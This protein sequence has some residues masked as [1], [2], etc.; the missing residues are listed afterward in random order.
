M[1]AADN[2]VDI[3]H[4]RLGHINESYLRIFCPF[5]P[6]YLSLSFC[7]ECAVCKQHKQP[8]TKTKTHIKQIIKQ[9]N[10]RNINK[11][12]II[13]DKYIKLYGRHKPGEYIVVDLKHMPP[14]LDGNLFLCTFTDKSTRLSTPVHLKLKSSFKYHYTT[15]LEYIKNKTGHYPKYIHS[16]GGGEFIDHTVRDINLSK[17][18]TH[19]F[20]SPDSSVQNPIAERINRTLS[21]GSMSL[22]VTACL[23]TLFWLYSIH[24]FTYIKNRTPHKDLNLSNPLTEWNIFNVTR[25]QIDIYDLRIWGC[26]A[27]VLD[28]H[29]KKNSPKAFRCIYLGPCFDHKGSNFY[30]L[31]TRKIIHSR[32]F[33]LNEQCFPGVELYPNLYTKYV[34]HKHYTK[35]L[36]PTSPTPTPLSTTTTT[37]T[38]TTTPPPPSSTTSTTTPTSTLSIP[39]HDMFLLNTTPTTSTYVAGNPTD[40]MNINN[41]TNEISAFHRDTHNL[42]T[43]IGDL[44]SLPTVTPTQPSPHPSSPSISPSTTSSSPSPAPFSIDDEPAW[45]VKAILGRRRTRFGPRHVNKTGYD[46]K[47]KWKGNHN[48]TWEP[49]RNLQSASDAIRAYELSLDPSYVPPPDK[50]S[51]ASSSNVS[52]GPPKMATAYTDREKQILGGDDHGPRTQNYFTNMCNFVNVPFLCYLSGILPSPTPL[53]SAWKNVKVPDT[54]TQMLRSPEVALWLL[55]EKEELDR[56]D[57]MQTWERVNKA[58]KKALT[59]RWVYKLKPPTTLQPEPIFKVRLV[60]HGYK[61]QAEIDYTSIYLFAQVATLKAFRIIMW[62]SVFFGLTCTQLD[63]K[64]AFLYGT[65]DKEIYMEPP[66]GYEHIGPVLL[67]KTLYGLRQSPKIW[68]STLIHEFHSLGFRE[69][70]SDSCVFYHP[71]KRFY[72]LIW[73][74]DII[75]CTKNEQHR[76]EVV[77]HLK[78]KFDLKDMGLLRHFVGLQV[79]YNDDDITI[80]QHD[81]A[82]KL[83][84]TFDD[85]NSVNSTPYDP[86]VKFSQ[87]QQPTTDDEKQKMSNYPYRQI[88]GSLLYLLITRPELYF[89]VIELS[90]FVSNPAYAHWLAAIHILRYVKLTPAV[91]L[92]LKKL[93]ELKLTVYCDSDWASN[94][95]DRKSTCGY[96][97]YLGSFPIVWR[98]RRQKGKP[99]TSS[100]EA[101]YRAIHEVLNEIVWIIAFMGELGL[102]VPTPVRV[103]CD[104]KSAN[105]LAYNPVHHDRTKHI[106]V[107]YH[108]IREY[109]LDGTIIV[110]HVPT[111]DNPADIFTKSVTGNIFNYLIKFIYNFPSKLS[112]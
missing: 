15:Y 62:I 46:Y 36:S 108:R 85:N 83:C 43:G 105:D 13:N 14:D 73:V 69:T 107:R 29:A 37:T 68:Y 81:Y 55:A 89:I 98:S 11:N 99:A 42:K 95:D 58:K 103:F 1:P 97:I 44:P 66:P 110:H 16:D 32:N 2:I 87:T 50:A 106:D 82:E 102:R 56:I 47:V 101:E 75:L 71:T 25:A 41:D 34:G 54:R 30:N 67:K 88:L 8:Y 109:I 6:K 76:T 96:I 64:T 78:S 4:K 112:V 31:Y 12:P 48:N 93:Q 59:C 52:L 19:T 49:E 9:H 65:L 90:R 77:T 21:E 60:V 57:S 38:T 10:K 7:T 91:G 104:N 63:I 17:G 24:T 53:S 18:I 74:D 94:V 72:I 92:V 70:I 33:T 5:L 26:E 20:T 86:T 35:Y 39:D 22:L 28:E 80:H 61:Q 45:E 3:W 40:Y 27:F 84:D 111:Q 100:C 79:D 51:S 23:P